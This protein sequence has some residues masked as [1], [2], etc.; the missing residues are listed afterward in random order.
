MKHSNSIRAELVVVRKEFVTPH[1][2]SVFFKSKQFNQLSHA[3]VGIH[4]KIMIP[5]KAATEIA[6]PEYDYLNN[7]WKPQS[8]NEKC[9]IRTY[10]LRAIDM[11]MEEIRIDFVYHG[12]DSPASAWAISAKEG[13]ILG[14]TMRGGKIDL[15]PA[16]SNYV[17]VGDATAIPVLSVI[18]GNLSSAARGVCI[19]EVHG[20][21]DQQEIFTNAD[22]EFIWLHNSNP[23]VGSG[24]A[25]MIKSRSLPNDSRFA[26]IAAEFTTVKEIRRFLRKDKLWKLEEVDAY[27]YW[28]KGVS[29]DHSADER[30][31]ENAED[32]DK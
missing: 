25:A 20:P 13:D 12:D 2:I 28:K 27:S 17:L 18:L 15:F 5:P 3:T 32:I 30:H 10:T 11:E 19:I 8:D 24:L 9:I 26:Y 23:L 7:C 1:Y 16:V 21:E 6:F 22:I 31:N 14:I 4:N 29:E